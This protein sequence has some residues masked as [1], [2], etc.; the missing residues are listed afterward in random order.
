[1]ASRSDDLLAVLKVLVEDALSKV[2]E[3]ELTPRSVSMSLGVDG[4]DQP[5]LFVDVVV[6]DPENA[7]WPFVSVM[8]VH[9]TVRDALKGGPYPRYPAYVTLVPE[10]H[11]AHE[12]D[13]Q[14]T[15]V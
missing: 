1:M 13:E 3:P 10:T 4:D 11:E 14:L 2:D 12:E 5:A 8:A 15:S 7:A 6:S 9:R